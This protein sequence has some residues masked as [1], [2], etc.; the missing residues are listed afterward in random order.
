M[1]AT[2]VHVR[3]VAAPESAVLHR[4]IYITLSQFQRTHSR[5]CKVLPS[6]RWRLR[7]GYFRRPSI[8]ALQTA[9]LH[10]GHLKV[11]VL[12]PGCRSRR[13]KAPPFIEA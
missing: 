8:A 5:C 11:I 10:R 2:A 4:G 7:T 9:I 3:E 13:W 1:R 6:S 12:P